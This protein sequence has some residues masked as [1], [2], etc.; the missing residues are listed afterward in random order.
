[1]DGFQGS[2]APDGEMWEPLVMDISTNKGQLLGLRFMVVSN[3]KSG[4]G[5]PHARR[6]P[7]VVAT[8]AKLCE[9]GGGLSWSE[10]PPG[11]TPK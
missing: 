7:G 6:P 3:R 2:A 11:Q 8:H 5:T 9:S 10:V 4:L 1:M